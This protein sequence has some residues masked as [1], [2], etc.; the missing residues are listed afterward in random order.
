[1]K[2]SLFV[3]ISASIVLSSSLF[4][5]GCGGGDNKFPNT[6]TPMV[7][8]MTNGSAGNQIIAFRPADDGAL[9]RFAAYSTGG[10]GTGTSEVS[11]ATPVDGI[12]PLASQGSLYISRDR[13]FLFA[14]NTAS[15][16]ISSFRVAG[17]GT[18]TLADTKPSGGTQPNCLNSFGSLLYVANVG[19]PSNSF[20]SNVTGFRVSDN[21]TL[22]QIAGSTR[23][24]STPNAQPAR[25][26][27]TPDGNLL[28]VSELT[29]NKITLFPVN[30]D[31]T[32]GAAKVNNSAG[33]AP[34]GSYFL[35]DG[36]L[37]VAQAPP[38]PTS[39]S[40]SSYTVS[41]DG[42]LTTVSGSIVNGQA[43]S[44]W[45]TPTRDEKYF[46]AS[47]TGN[48]TISS[49]A[50]NSGGAISLLQGV[51]SNL[52]GK[53]G[54]VDAGVSRDGRYFYVL[55]SGSG[56]VIAHRI[57]NDGSLTIL[58]TVTGQGLPAL[59]TEGLAIH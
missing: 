14:V 20:A 39:G 12:D 22:T 1:M 59:G 44:C 27:F 48:G 53:P 58:Q 28:V 10:N 3:G 35:S 13:R 5:A 36:R 33:L 15:A 37:I 40:A 43:A 52:D 32:L 31:G 29:T 38:P 23:S 41:S 51:A 8:A 42:T 57:N 21:G 11:S 46:Y 25:V 16:T 2:R 50:I 4:L 54:A 56:S 45:I 18:L 19:D 24:L 6:D 9:T 17:D 55:N 47:N 34:F 49:Y 7:Y 30:N 26:L